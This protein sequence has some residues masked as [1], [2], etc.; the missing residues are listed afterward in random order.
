VLRF[1]AYNDDV[2][3]RLSWIRDTLGPSL[4]RALS[5]RTVDLFS[6]I[7]RALS[8]GDEC[9]NRNAAASSILFR[10][11]TPLVIASDASKAQEVLEFINRN[12]HFFL[13][14]SMAACKSALE[15]GA[16][17]K[18]STLV[19]TM[20][21]NGVDFGL[22]LSGSGNQWFTCASPVV[23]GLF[24]PGYSKKDANPDLGDSSIT[25][26]L[27]I[28]GA[29]MA[30]SPAITGFVGGNAASALRT[31]KDMYRIYMAKH[32]RMTIPSLDF[33]GVPLGLDAL[34]VLETNEMPVINTGIAHREAG[35]GQIGAGIC[36]APAPVFQAAVQ[37]VWLSLVPS[38]SYS[39]KFAIRALKMLK[40]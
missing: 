8:M 16:N 23:E 37:Q 9:H 30:A 6:I 4:G 3:K 22:R 28:G 35:V 10:E 5:G 15:A 31:T 36:R 11:L 7:A 38:S 2:I 14:L 19:T 26:T 1:G 25:E 40:K 34:R 20:A 32:P 33:Q 27:G 39:Q 17:V 12:D 18:G 21:R 24:F 13:N 29:A